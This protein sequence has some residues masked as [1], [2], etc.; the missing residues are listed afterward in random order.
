MVVS[1]FAAVFSMIV[2]L[3]EVTL[4]LQVDLSVFGNLIKLCQGFVETEVPYEFNLI[5]ISFYLKQIF[6]LIPLLYIS[7][8][9]FVGLFN[10]KLSGFFGLYK[11]HQTDGPSLMFSS[12]N[13]SR[14]SAPLCFNFLQ[15]I[16]IKS[17]TFNTVDLFLFFT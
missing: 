3:S 5:S 10:L 9:V 4:F 1:V 17:T 6:T 8:A 16:K 12:L 14:V 15:I 7:F 2:I 13:F 11:H